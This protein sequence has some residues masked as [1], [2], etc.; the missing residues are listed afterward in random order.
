MVSL[1]FVLKGEKRH[2]EFHPFALL[3]PSPPL[4]SMTL[5]FEDAGVGSPTTP[6]E[7]GQPST[8][9]CFVF[10]KLKYISRDQKFSKLLVHCFLFFKL[11]LVIKLTQKSLEPVALVL[12]FC[13]SN[14]R[15]LRAI[16]CLISTAF[17]ISK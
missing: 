8:A 2:F 5:G 17:K 9:V 7:K 10:L 11:D 13:T 14:T 16:P 15:S 3:S 4:P 6:G 12:L 1:Q